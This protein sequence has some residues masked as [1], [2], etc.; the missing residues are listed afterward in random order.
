MKESLIIII[1]WIIKIAETAPIK[2]FS[3]DS[4]NLDV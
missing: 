1:K 3:F 4:K 2:W